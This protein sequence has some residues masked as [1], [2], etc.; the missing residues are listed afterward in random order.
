MRVRKSIWMPGLFA[1]IALVIVACG[2]D[3][4]ATP[5]PT[6]DATVSPTA[7]AGSQQ[8]TSDLTAEE[9]AYLR[10]VLRAERSSEAIFEGFRTVFAQSY[11]VR[12]ALISALLQAG[13]GTPFVEK[14]AILEALDP[15]ERF[16]DD[17]QIWL[18]SARELLRIDTEATAAAQA[19]DLV[20]F[21]VL[22]GQL[23][24]VATAAKI[25]LS[26]SYCL[27]IS[28]TEIGKAICTSDDTNLGGGYQTVLNSMIRGFMPEFVNLQGNIGFRLSLTPEEL[29]Q[30]LSETGAASR[31]TIQGFASELEEIVP[32]EELSADHERLQTFLGRAVEILA[33]VN[34]LGE[35]GDYQGASGELQKLEPT[36]CD[37][38][39][40]LENKD[41]KDAVGIFFSGDPRTCGGAPF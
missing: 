24:G 13:V 11:P 19:G 41:F 18:E 40:S 1:V 21:S 6:P 3:A 37:T 14:T 30:L 33:E 23:G 22:N 7:E 20:R 26:P 31:K 35:A 9:S 34:R 4:T 39:A 12:E 10:E 28:S 2:S 38:R 17:H 32:P 25:A 36:F 29:N 8:E 16:R 27:G 5:L 15:P